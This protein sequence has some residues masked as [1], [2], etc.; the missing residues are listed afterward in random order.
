[1]ANFSAAF[2]KPVYAA[3]RMVVGFLFACHGAQKL[4]GV[5]GGGGN[6]PVFGLH[7]FHHAST[8]VIAAGVI[9]F[10]AGTLIAIGLLTHFAAFLASGEMAFA[11]FTVHAHGSFFPIVNKGELAVLYCFVFLYIA[12]RGVGRW[13]IDKS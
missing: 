5:P 1:M 11:Y 9:E 6:V 7:G 8:S 2:E 4:F 3:V 10:G 12:V 13:G